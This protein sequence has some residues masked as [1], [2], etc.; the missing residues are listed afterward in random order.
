[1][2]LSPNI[3]DSE[4]VEALIARVKAIIMEELITMENTTAGDQFR[5]Q[6]AVDLNTLL[7]ACDDYLLLYGDASQQGPNA[8]RTR[9]FIVS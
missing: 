3:W 8:D 2:I 9:T 7:I 4:D 6:F 1:M 5:K